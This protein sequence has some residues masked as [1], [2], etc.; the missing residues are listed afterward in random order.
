M[1]KEVKKLIRDTTDK[2]NTSVN[3]YHE[4]VNVA[5]EIKTNEII[6]HLPSE[7]MVMVDP[8]R[9]HFNGYH[10]WILTKD[11]LDIFFAGHS[12]LHRV[13]EDFSMLN[14][15]K[16]EEALYMKVGH[17]SKIK[18]L[19]IDPTWDFIE[20][21]ANAENQSIKD[22]S[23]HLSITLKIIGNL[24]GLFETRKT[25][26]NGSIEIKTCRN[27][28]QYAYHRVI[29]TYKS[30]E[31]P[32]IF[33]GFYFQDTVG[34]NTPL[35]KVE[36]KSIVDFFEA[37]FLHIWN[38]PSSRTLFDYRSNRNDATID[39]DYYEECRQKLKENT[40][41]SDFDKDCPN[42]LK[43]CET[44]SADNIRNESLIVN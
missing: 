10:R 40:K 12:V 43:I 30:K 39:T 29:N 26:L 7:S 17:S 9:K 38:A 3:G 23:E 31:H 22:I 19:L 24:Y 16:C 37:H 41:K 4:N 14:L 25:K 33:I 34:S 32:E 15:P 27:I 6:T 2:I 1:H 28:T 18:I 11:P 36:N 44:I 5:Y 13:D 35:F 42:L 21:I 8:E 20:D